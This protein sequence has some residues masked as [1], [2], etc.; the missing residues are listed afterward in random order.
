MARTDDPN[1]A[2]DQFFV[3][4]EARTGPANG[5]DNESAVEVMPVAEEIAWNCL[6]LSLPQTSPDSHPFVSLG[7]QSATELQIRV[8]DWVTIRPGMRIIYH[9]DRDDMCASCF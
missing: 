5:D 8:T 7:S 2:T 6:Q 3:N 9:N 4:V 1:S